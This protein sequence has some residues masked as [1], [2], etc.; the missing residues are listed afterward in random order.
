MLRGKHDP[1]WKDTVESWKATQLELRKR[2]IVQPLDPLPRFVAGVD[3]AFS[4]DKLRVFAAAVVYDVEERRVVEVRHAI[5][6]AQVPY[7][8]GFLSF[9]EGPAVLEA[10][11]KLTHEWG[12]IC[13][14]GQGYAHPRRCGLAAHMSITLGVP[15]VGV[16]KSRLIGTFDEPGPRAGDFSPLMD[17]GEQ[18]GI[19]LRT[20][21]HTRPLFISLGNRIDLESARQLVL[22][23]CTRYRIPEPTRQ[24]D[25]EVG[26]L[27]RRSS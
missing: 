20:R 6:P 11:G 7:V 14:D 9:R 10:V 19:V 24:A 13:F 3:A 15:G 17:Q 25:I 5:R 22:A 1:D 21:D 2:T 18:I 8:P 26:R 12:A 27:K 16:A 23:C 4:Q